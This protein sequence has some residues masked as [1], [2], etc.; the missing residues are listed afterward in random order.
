M[1]RLLAL[2]G[3]A[4][5]LLGILLLLG[6][7]VFRLSP[8]ALDFFYDPVLWFHWVFL[9]LSMVFMAWSEGYRGFQK[10]FSPRVAARMH[11]LYNNPRPHLLIFAPLFG[12][13]LI[14]APLRRR[15]ITVVIMVMVITLVVLVR[16]IA[17]PWRGIID[18]GVV[19][20]LVYGII[21]LIYFVVRAFMGKALSHSPE[22]A[23]E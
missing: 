14:H 10:G 22:L 18:A 16:S 19:T 15:L 12:L 17:Q 7:A 13:G 6:S 5:G 1:Q 23:E 3:V 4:W 9:A 21:S 20:G 8:L 11:W 2:T